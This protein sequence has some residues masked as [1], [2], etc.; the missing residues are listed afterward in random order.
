MRRVA[1]K[2]QRRRETGLLGAR[3]GTRWQAGTGHQL[4]GLG[5][6]ASFH[7]RSLS[8]VLRWGPG[9]GSWR[10]SQEQVPRGLGRVVT[11]LERRRDMVE[12]AV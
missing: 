1:G 2:I 10:G 3:A 5:K 8:L 11:G 6:V 12:G 4:Y 7:A 9:A